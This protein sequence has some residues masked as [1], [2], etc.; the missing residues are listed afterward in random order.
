MQNLH[1][2][3]RDVMQNCESLEDS[4]KKLPESSYQK[5]TPPTSNLA[6]LSVDHEKI[7]LMQTS[8]FSTRKFLKI[9]GEPFFEFF[10]DNNKFEDFA[11]TA[12]R[13]LQQNALKRSNYPHANPPSKVTIF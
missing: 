2:M 11:M 12:D 7:E 6:T 5:T 10:Y 4:M 8:V 13:V 3:L 9:R 1:D